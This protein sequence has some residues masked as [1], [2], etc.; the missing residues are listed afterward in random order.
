MGTGEDDA[1]RERGERFRGAVSSCAT[2][3]PLGLMRWRA[4]PGAS[5]GGFRSAKATRANPRSR[6]LW[7]RCGRPSASTW[8]EPT[9]TCLGRSAFISF[10]V[11]NAAISGFLFA[12]AHSKYI[13]DA[14]VRRR[15]HDEDAPF[16]GFR[17]HERKPRIGD[18][19]C[20]WRMTPVDFAEAGV[21]NA[22][23][24]HCDVVVEVKSTTVRALGG[25]VGNSVRLKTFALDDRGFLKPGNR[26][27]AL[28]ANRGA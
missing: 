1:G 15:A 7:A 13:H 21:S 4:R 5:S 26:L 2:P 11:R 20:Q 3:A 22:F 25:N 6:S 19:T 23:R 24:S 18:L 9:P 14:I 17:L 27:F 10:V 16:W 12:A 28:M 8:T